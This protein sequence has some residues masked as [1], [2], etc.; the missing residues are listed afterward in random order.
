MKDRLFPAKNG[1]SEG[2]T[3][4]GSLDS[5]WDAGMQGRPT[6][7]RTDL[8][9]NLRARAKFAH[10][11]LPLLKWETKDPTWDPSS[12]FQHMLVEYLLCAK[13]CVGH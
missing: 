9:G 3:G 1:E 7:S 6:G 10:F 13:H 5:G 8:G 12:F 4:E 2:F 11:D